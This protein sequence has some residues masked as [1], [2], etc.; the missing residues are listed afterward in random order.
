MGNIY[1]TYVVTTSPNGEEM[2]LFQQSF[3]IEFENGNSNP[4]TDKTWIAGVVVGIIALATLVVGAIFYTKRRHQSE[5]R[6]SSTRSKSTSRDHNDLYETTG[7]QTAEHH[8][9]S[10]VKDKDTDQQHIYSTIP[11]VGNEN[12]VL[13]NQDTNDA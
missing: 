10:S 11:G 1:S 5:N 9:I 13:Q 6:E 7:Y 3:V 12:V 4:E 2:V 8:N